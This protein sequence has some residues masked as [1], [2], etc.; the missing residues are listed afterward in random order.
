VGVVTVSRLFGAGGTRVSTAVAEALGYTVVDREL[1]EMAARHAG[2]DP[3]AARHLDERA[4]ALIERAGFALAAASPEFGL[5]V[6]PPLDDRA[7]ADGVRAVIA[8]L[9]ETGGYVILG[10]GGQAALRDRDEVVHLQLVGSLD[11]RARSVAEWQGI[12]F[13]EARDRC[14][15]VDAERAEYVRRV[16]GFDIADPLLYEAVLN[17]SRLGLEGASA[18]AVEIS[19][20]RLGLTPSA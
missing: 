13:A 10:R 4:P 20:R 11:D 8:S 16:H 9:A 6:P 7:L 1:V 2:I 14:R 3:E 17:T 19:R 18:A 15:R 12:G 5:E